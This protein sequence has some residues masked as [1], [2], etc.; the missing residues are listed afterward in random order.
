MVALLED[1][2]RDEEVQVAVAENATAEGALEVAQ[3]IPDEISLELTWR[4]IRRGQ[5]VDPLACA[6]ALA[7]RRAYGGPIS[8]KA[9]GLWLK[10]A[11]FLASP[12]MMR[13]VR[14]FDHC[15]WLRPLSLLWL[16]PIR[17]TLRR[18]T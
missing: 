14:R 6:F 16:R 8:V 5:P 11:W 18:M 3:E 15:A 13:W 1:V 12:E 9:N 17:V 2:L 4:D 10:G 7:A